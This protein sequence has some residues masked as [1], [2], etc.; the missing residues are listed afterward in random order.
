MEDSCQ[1][2]GGRHRTGACTEA[3]FIKE[4]IQKTPTLPRDVQTSLDVFLRN[5]TQR[6]GSFEDS[7]MRISEIEGK[8]A[9]DPALFRDVRA[10]L[11]ESSVPAAA[12]MILDF[13]R[14]VA[15]KLQSGIKEFLGVVINE[16]DD[17]SAESARGIIEEI[18][19][20]DIHKHAD[21]LR[22]IRAELEE[23]KFRQPPPEY[24]DMSPYEIEN[25][26]NLLPKNV[27]LLPDAARIL[28]MPLDDAQGELAKLK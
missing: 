26:L 15:R 14:S 24:P 10:Y 21:A 6:G 1:V 18:L 4:E 3:G 28:Q 20:L 9:N 13:E 22:K 7:P 12:G 16:T 17:M 11:A 5:S 2:C 27:S 8:L 25:L 23:S 19:K